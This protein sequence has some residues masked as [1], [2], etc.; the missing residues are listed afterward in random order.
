M[1][2]SYKIL[3]GKAEGRRPIGELKVGGR[4]ILKWGTRCGLVSSISQNSDG[5]R[6]LVSTIMNIRVPTHAGKILD[7]LSVLLAPKGLCSMAL[8]VTA[9]KH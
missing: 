5:W 6:S 1:S 4:I 8:L 3:V 2:N 9:A 7:Q